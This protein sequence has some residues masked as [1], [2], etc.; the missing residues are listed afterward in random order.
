MLKSNGIIIKSSGGFYYVETPDGTIIECRA[1]GKFRKLNL[2]P[3]VGD[4]VSVEFGNDL[5]GTVSQVYER[6]NSFNRPPVANV[7]RF[8]IISSAS[9]PVPNLFIID[10]LTAISFSRN[11][12]PFVIFSKCDLADT[13]GL[14]DIYNRAGI[15]S[16]A[17]SAFTGENIDRFRDLISTGYSVLTGN[18]G[19]GKSSLL[20]ACDPSLNL[21]TGEISEALGRG[22]HTTR[23]VEMFRVLNGRVTDTPGFSSLDGKGGE[24]IRKEQLADCFPEFK[25]YSL[26]CRFPDCAH[27]NDKGCAVREAV[28]NNM[29]P[30]E[31]YASYKQM[32]E[33]VIDLPS[34]K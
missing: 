2:S 7:D 18:T 33:E 31:R 23:T 9:S 10:K 6:I 3:L 27:L 11:V 5:K 12:I 8:I 4:K 34:W 24:I 25:P 29:I 22:R 17:V 1:K 28:S 20:N 16:F 21:A 26:D 30:P 15:E 32:L 13:T 14:T 19:V